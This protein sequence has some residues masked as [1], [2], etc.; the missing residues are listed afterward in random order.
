MAV[1]QDNL[2]RALFNK[3]TLILHG[4]IRD[5]AYV[6]QRQIVPGF[7]P[8]LRQIAR[9]NGMQRI[10]HLGVTGDGRGNREGGLWTVEREEL[11]NDD[12]VT[13]RKT[14][15]NPARVLA[16]WL[17]E[18][19]ERPGPRTL[20]VIHYLDKLTPYVSS[21]LYPQDVMDSLSLIQ[22]LIENIGPGHRL[23]MIALRDTMIPVEYY[24]D[25]PGTSV[26]RIPL[27]DR[28]ERRFYFGQS[29]AQ[30]APDQ[31]DLLAN[32]TD[33]LH[34]LDLINLSSD[35]AADRPGS[36]GDMKKR[37]NRYRLG[38]REDPWESLPLAG[39]AKGLLDTAEAWFLGRVKGQDH[40]VRYL[41]KSL[42]KARAGLTGVAS[43]QTAKPRGVFF[44]AGPTGVGKTFLAK[45][46]AEFLF[47][48]G[49]AFLR[50]DMSEFK[51]DHSVSKLIGSP[52]GYV[53]F[54]QGGMLT[55]AVRDRPF[56]VVLFDEVEKAHPRILDI[57]LQILDDG[58]LTDSRGQTVFFTETVII[59]TSNLGTRATDSRGHPIEEKH[60]LEQILETGDSPR[61]TQAIQA[62]FRQA[63]QDFFTYEISRP[64]L[65]NR[66]G[67]NIIPFN[68]IES[69]AVQYD[70]F[71]SKLREIE[72]GFN[73]K[74][75]EA[76]HRLCIEDTVADYFIA[77]HGEQI[78]RFGGRGLVNAIED[79]I[80]T[81]L[82]DY[83]LDSESRNERGRRFQIVWHRTQ[84]RLICDVVPDRAP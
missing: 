13:A 50:F 14:G 62:H 45:K 83:L 24:A 78:R 21:G 61:R 29:L 44:F 52:P 20:F 57:F 39:G 32:L 63:V 69:E 23:F 54:E 12:T 41:L 79:E 47:D 60:E 84:N 82:A 51:E 72:D 28:E 80:I 17:K 70:I 6:Y 76:G 42:R 66:F 26:H 75:G 58:R 64:E 43:G 31:L 77:R 49:E 53:G 22:K 5:K 33:G 38:S 65:L 67:A 27:P 11:L 8:L 1:W 4:N 25:A 48:T 36:T 30:L 68:H 10:L 9:E 56:S 71:V 46:L 40:A 16:R 34:F 55:N 37:I 35:L 59:F 18:E 73:D 19:I 15:K 74:Y 81:L 2:N 3:Q 7:T